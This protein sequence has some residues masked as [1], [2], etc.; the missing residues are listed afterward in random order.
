MTG[1]TDLT[2]LLHNLSPSLNPQDYV[3]CTIADAAYGDFAEHKPLASFMETEG[4]TLVLLKSS[5]D[6][7]GLTYEGSF[8][9]ITLNV[10]SSLEAVGLTA[11]VATRLAEQGISANVIA[12]FFHDHIFV[13]SADA[14]RALAALQSDSFKI[15]AEDLV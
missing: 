5:A 12:A 4:L 3:F 10:H 6:K 15:V 1:E 13:A 11:A 7:A 14:D 9:C 2:T 8:K